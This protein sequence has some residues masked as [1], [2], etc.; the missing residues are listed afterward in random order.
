MDNGHK[1]YEGNIS[2]LHKN[3]NVKILVAFLQK[4]HVKYLLV[5]GGGSRKFSKE[6]LHMLWKKKDAQN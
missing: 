4:D 6:I 5:V 2:L 1:V 3:K